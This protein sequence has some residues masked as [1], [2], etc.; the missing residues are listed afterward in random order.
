MYVRV[1]VIGD[2][3]FHPQVIDKEASRL[4]DLALERTRHNIATLAPKKTGRLAGSFY[5]HRTGKGSGQVTS[6]LVYAAIQDIGG[7]IYPKN[8][9]YL[10]FMG[11]EGNWVYTKGP[12]KIPATHYFT[13]GIQETKESLHGLLIETGDNIALGMGFYGG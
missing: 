5:I 8:V 10:R 7:L 13:M 2:T 4:V 11:K 9:T 1:Q 12:V 6:D 3:S